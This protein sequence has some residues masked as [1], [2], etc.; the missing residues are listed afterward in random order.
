MKLF[1]EI[2]SWTHLLCG[3]IGG[4]ITLVMSVTGLLLTYEKQMTVWA[5][6]RDLRVSAAYRSR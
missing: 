2:L 1:R 4:V 5:D 6:T 3:V